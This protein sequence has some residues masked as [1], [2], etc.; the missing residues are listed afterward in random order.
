MHIQIATNDGWP[1]KLRDQIYIS[2]KE[3][4][5]RNSERERE[6]IQT[7]SSPEVLSPVGW[8][9]RGSLKSRGLS[10]V[11]QNSVEYVE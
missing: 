10:R 1:E 2:L 3:V 7:S 4:S 9:H 8:L 6:N 5:Q 11:E